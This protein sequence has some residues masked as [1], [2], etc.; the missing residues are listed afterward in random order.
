MIAHYA[1]FM[2]SH[3]LWDGL[4]FV[5]GVWWIHRVCRKPHFRRFRGAELAVLLIWGQVSELLVELSST[6]VDGWVFVGYGW[7]PVIFRFNGHDIR[8][9]MQ[10]VWA[11]ASSKNCSPH[12]SHTRAGISSTTTKP[13]SFQKM[14]ETV[15][16]YVED[17]H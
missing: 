10:I 5:I 12:P 15:L 11:V 7:N 1:V 16:S 9:F 14:A 17:A 13:R 8:W 3:T 4:L 6:Y 2:V